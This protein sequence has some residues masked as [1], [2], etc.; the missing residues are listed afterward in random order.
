MKNPNYS[1]ETAHLSSEADKARWEAGGREKEKRERA[2]LE[3]FKAKF[4]KLPKV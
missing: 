4:E 2:K 3:R 1:A